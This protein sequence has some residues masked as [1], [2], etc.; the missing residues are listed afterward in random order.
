MASQIAKEVQWTLKFLVSKKEVTINFIMY[1]NCPT[2]VANFASLSDP[3]KV[4]EAK[5]YRNVYAHRVIPGFMV[6]IGDTTNAKLVWTPGQDKPSLSGRNPGT[7]GASIYGEK[8]KDENFINKHGAGVLSMANAGKDTNGSQIFIV[9]STRNT[10]HLNGAHV[11]FGRVKSQEDYDSVKAIEAIGSG[12]GDI[13][14][15]VYI[16]DCK[17]VS[18]YTQ[19]EINEELKKAEIVEKKGGKCEFLHGYPPPKTTQND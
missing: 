6:Q 11:V 1:P 14:D 7:G 12:S 18:Y 8:F 16:S 10:Q 4:G 2:T 19:E 3:S 17:I 15:Y 5:S 13:R 9:T